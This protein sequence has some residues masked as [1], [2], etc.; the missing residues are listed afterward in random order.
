[1]YNFAKAYRR[2]QNPLPIT[3]SIG[4]K[5]SNGH[6]K[7]TTRLFNGPW[8]DPV[9]EH[10]CTQPFKMWNRLRF[11]PFLKV[12]QIFQKHKSDA[13]KQDFETKLNLT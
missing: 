9:G 7:D 12:V 13:N 4:S 3:E 10:I 2:I 6:T 5:A 11:H 8:Y 1:M